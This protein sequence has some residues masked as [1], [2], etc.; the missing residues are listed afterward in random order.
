MSRA[1]LQEAPVTPESTVIRERPVIASGRASPERGRIGPGLRWAAAQA[2]LHAGAVALGFLSFVLLFQL[3]L[4][5]GIT[6]LFYRGLVLLGLAFAVTLALT[7]WLAGHFARTGLR[8]RDALAACILSLS[9]N[10]SFLVLFPVTV[11]RSISVFM[12]GQ[13]AAHPD[14]VVT[15]AQMRATFQDV[16]LGEYRQIE[17]RMDEQALS[18]NVV[19]VGDGY[20]I[21]PQGRA[22]IRLSGLIARA[23]RT[24]PRLV[25]GTAPPHRD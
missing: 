12:L 15:P 3:D 20:R 4:G 24:D 25:A 10:L 11:D 23:F 16:Y 18:G 17:R 13:M 6:I 1:S 8:R 5:A 19:P 7:T 14:D 22:F 21:T 9:L 2:V